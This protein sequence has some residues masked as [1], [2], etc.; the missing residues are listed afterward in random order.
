[1]T[2]DPALSYTPNQTAVC[3]FGMATNEKWTSKGGEKKEKVCFVDCRA[4]G[5]LAENINKYF[6]KGR[7]IHIEGVLE[8]DQWEAQDGSKRSKHRIKVIGFSF[9]GSAE[10]TE[11][12]L[13][14]EPNSDD[15]GDIPF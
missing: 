4:F 7:A 9:V 6:S 8:L 5:K 15:Y 13:D 1:M 2:K 14:R 11:P 10:Q 12:P 3:D